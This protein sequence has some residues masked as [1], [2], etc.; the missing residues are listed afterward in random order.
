MIEDKASKCARTLEPARA[1]PSTLVDKG[2][3]VVEHLS[4]APDNEL[5]SAAKVTAESTPASVVEMLHEK[6][7]G[8]V[9]NASDPRLLTL[10]SHLAC[11]TRQ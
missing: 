9:S 7:F 6:M 2:K 1:A 3:K 4:S 5:L 11:S 10:I 8:G